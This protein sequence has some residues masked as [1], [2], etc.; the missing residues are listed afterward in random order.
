MVMEQAHKEKALVPADVWAPAVQ[1]KEK[2]A[3]KEAAGDKAVLAAR[4]KEKEK[5]AARGKDEAADRISEL[6]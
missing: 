1:V 2:V 6:S 3:V 5:A 4:A